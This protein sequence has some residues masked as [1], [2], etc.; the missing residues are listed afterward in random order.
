MIRHALSSRGAKT[1]IHAGA[2]ALLIIAAASAVGHSRAFIAPG[3]PLNDT[4]EPLEQPGSSRIGGRVDDDRLEELLAISP[5]PV[6]VLGLTAT[7]LS[8]CEDLGRQL[9]HVQR[10]IRG[11]GS[12]V[13]VTDRVSFDIV[14]RFLAAERVDPSAIL[15]YRTI[16]DPLTM[17]AVPPGTYAVLANSDGSLL[18][19][20]LHS[21]TSVGTRRDSFVE[22]LALK[23]H[24]LAIKKQ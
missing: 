3:A 12:L 17:K 18:S 7:S 6:V 2:S 24:M 16:G 10:E 13:I 20:V 21:L 1:V 5:P 22:E 14:R 11:K 9:R 4:R 8:A 15:T 19:G 23:H